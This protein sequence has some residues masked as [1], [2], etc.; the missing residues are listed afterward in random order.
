KAMT[1]LTVEQITKLQK[2]YGVTGT[3]DGINSGQCWRMEGSVGRFASEM[4]EAGVCMLPEERKSDY[5]GNT[6]PSRNDLKAGTK[7]TL[8]N[9]Q[10]FWQR[11]EESDFEAIDA[12]E[13]T[14]GVQ[15][16]NKE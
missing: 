14:F 11:V 1:K 6:V 16:E 7:G 12:L 13:A 15:S 3:Q 4:L 9:C 10:N 8:L 2:E 5:Y